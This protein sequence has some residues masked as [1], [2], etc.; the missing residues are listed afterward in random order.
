MP[1]R[2]CRA[3]KETITAASTISPFVP[4]ST[5]N[6]VPGRMSNSAANIAL[7]SVAPTKPAILG[8]EGD[9][10]LRIHLQIDPTGGAVD[11]A[12]KQP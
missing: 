9:L 6:F 12:A 8:G 7:D 4:R 3:G 10:R 1:A 5:S 11:Y 2:R